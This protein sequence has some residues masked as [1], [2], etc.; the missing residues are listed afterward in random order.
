MQPEH[1]PELKDE[2]ALFYRI[3]THHGTSFLSES[4]TGLICHGTETRRASDFRHVLVWVPET[5]TNICFLLPSNSAN[6]GLRLKVDEGPLEA[7][8]LRLAQMG[9]GAVALAHPAAGYLC[10][11]RSEDR[12]GRIVANRTEVGPWEKFA[13]VQVSSVPKSVLAAARKLNVIL[14]RTRTAHDALENLESTA[15]NHSLRRLLPSVL[16]LLQ[17]YE[18][19]WLGRALGQDRAA[20]EAFASLF[21]DDVW[22]REALPGLHASN[23]PAEPAPAF[24]RT[25]GPSTDHLATAGFDGEYVSVAQ[26]CNA[27]ARRA[28]AP[29]RDLCLLTTA[30]NE[31]L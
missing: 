14:E 17:P 5:R 21:E 29:S 16:G 3:Q 25:I 12:H 30:R 11:E 1:I 19:E 15:A 24:E 7:I 23:P 10:A 4:A 2:S 9:D 20:A 22:A 28:R 13:L 6:H 18:M 8:G 26:L 27:F 31:G